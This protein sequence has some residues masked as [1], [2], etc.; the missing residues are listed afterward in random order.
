MTYAS[1]IASLAV[2]A[3]VI[4]AIPALAQQGKLEPP[5]TKYFAGNGSWG[6]SYPDQWYLQRIGFDLS[7]DSAWR[8]V[9]RDATP[10]T[11]AVID[12]GIDWNHKNF[13]W[14]NMWFNP[15]EVADNGLDDDGNGYIDDVIGWDFVDGYGKPWD[16]EGHGTFV[17]GLIAGSWKDKDGIA[18]VNPLARIMIVKAISNLG[19]SRASYVAQAIT[20]AVDNGARVI[21]LSVGGRGLSAL[22]GIAIDYAYQ[23]GAV[24]V[25]A[26]GN[27][28]IN[29]ADFGFGG[30]TKVLTV[31]A[32]GLKD[33]HPNFSNWGAVSVAAPGIDILSLRARRTDVLLN[34]ENSGYTDGKAF[35]GADKRHYRASGTS[36]ATPLVAGLASLMIAND[37]SLTNRQVMDIIMST[38]RDVGTTG[39]DQFTGYGVIDARAALK[40]A[41]DYRLLAGIKGVSVIVKDKAQF[42]RV[43]G[44]ADASALKV[45]R[46]EIGTG[47]DP[48]K[49]KRVGTIGKSV[50]DASGVL[51]DIPANEFAGAKVWQIR[52]VVTH[53]NGAT[54]EARFRLN[55]G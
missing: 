18:G 4:S 41:K 28:G 33:E 49:W 34:V 6:Q 44:I 25:V 42:V 1:V 12:T 50:T 48:K 55:L 26:S 2:A 30:N 45:A 22:E 17:A 15:K 14:D 53:N 11:V 24:L 3:S 40:A 35:V 46:L 13:N 52:V 16:Y 31:G 37:P 10:V 20:Y 7:K 27:E 29:N 9:K 32:T 8:L 21:N 54:R 38:A 23:K 19:K 36:F 39:V 47:E 43:N 5:K 51:G